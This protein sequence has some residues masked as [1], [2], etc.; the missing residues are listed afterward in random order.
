[1]SDC[2]FHPCIICD[3]EALRTEW[4][5]G[6]DTVEPPNNGHVWDPAEVEYYM[7][8]PWWSHYNM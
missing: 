3:L 1:M 7:T 5:G 4:G 2:Y 8:H 6:M